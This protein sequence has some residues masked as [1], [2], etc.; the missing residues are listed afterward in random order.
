M[1]KLKRVVVVLAALIVAY[2]AIGGILYLCGFRI[3]RIPSSAMEPT[4]RKDEMV[5]GR[6]SDS[7][8]RH[9]ER[10]DIAIYRLPQAP[11]EVY[12]KRVAALAGEH[13]VIGKDGVSV[14]GKKVALPHPVVPAGRGAIDVSVPAGS[15]YLVGDNT[16]NSMDSRYHGPVPINDIIGYLVFKR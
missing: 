5:I 10:L 1:K 16:S 7:Y 15:V 6:L 2:H 11:G 14:G 13:V 9:V 3:Y 4:I 12:A 8:R